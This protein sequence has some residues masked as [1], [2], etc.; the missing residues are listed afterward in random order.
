MDFIFLIVLFLIS[1]SFAKSLFKMAKFKIADFQEEIIFCLLTGLGLAAYFVFFLGLAGLIYEKY[2]LILLLSMAL[3]SLREMLD[4]L[5]AITAAIRRFSLKAMPLNEKAIWFFLFAAIFLTF[6]SALSAPVCNDSLAYRLAHIRIFSQNHRIF[7]IPYT[8][9]SLWP[10]LM[11]MLYILAYTIK[12]DILIKLISWSF[13][14]IGTLLIYAFSKKFLTKKTALYASAVF[15]LTPAIFLQITTTYVDVALAVYA[16]AALFALINYFTDN[17]TKWAVVSGIL[18]GL[19]LSIKYTALLILPAF[20]AVFLYYFIALKEKRFVL[21]GVFIFGVF[22]FLFG[23]AWYIRAYTIKG[24][25]LY[26]FFA[27]IFSGHGWMR[28]IDENV[29]KGFSLIN[30]LRLPWDLTMHPEKFGN[31]NIGIFYLLFAPAAFLAYRSKK[32]LKVL[33]I[34]IAVCVI[35]WFMVVPYTAR[36]LLPVLL[37]LSLFIGYGLYSLFNDKGFFAKAIKIIFVLCCLL[38]ISYLAISNIDEF[39]AG[40]GLE[41][42]QN[43]LLRTERTYKMASYINDNLPVDSNILMIAEVRSYYINRPFIH[44]RNLIDEEKIS[45]KTLNREQFLKDL[46]YKYK[47]DY[48]LYS[49]DGLSYPWLKTI[50]DKARRVFEYDFLDREGRRFSYC[51]YNIKDM[52]G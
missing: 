46:I 30:F 2:I 41:S 24:N 42:R 47:I 31:E 7:Y 13:G 50:V 34:F 19:L 17:N 49:K 39:K 35:A 51:L 6:I 16:F 28:A 12:S 48:V 29:S 15:L 10:Y 45:D 5:K 26:P 27:R 21:K 1:T 38:N 36:C 11:E 43:Y 18:C 33:I 20:A 40:L 8:R 22:A 4:L 32:T 37:P 25:P 3:V 44:F 14:L 23:C 52:A 9:E